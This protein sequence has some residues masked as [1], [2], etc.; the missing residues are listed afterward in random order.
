M[1]PKFKIGQVVMAKQWKGCPGSYPFPPMWVIGEV[2]SIAVEKEYTVYNFGGAYNA[3]ESEL[4]D[5][6]HLRYER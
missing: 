4:E 2:N 1:S 6:E 3:K 5:G